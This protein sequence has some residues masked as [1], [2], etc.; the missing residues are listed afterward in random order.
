MLNRSYTSLLFLLTACLLLS[1]MFCPLYDIQIDDKDVYHY[2]GM[3]ILRGGVPYRDFFDHKPPLIF[4]LNAAGLLIGGWG[5]WVIDLAL[6]VL[7]T[8]VFF[9]TCERHKLPFPWLL[10]LLFNLMLR[11]FLISLGMGMT[12]GYTTMLQL[13]FFCVLIERRRYR[14]VIAGL[15]AGLIFFMQQDQV[16]F[17]APFLVASW[18]STGVQTVVKRLIWFAAG[19]GIILVP[20]LI[21]FVARG[22]L[23][24][25]WQDA[26]QF[27]FSWYTAQKG[28]LGYHFRIIKEALDAGNYEVPFLVSATLGFAALFL[29][30]RRKGWVIAGLAGLL[31]SMS[32]ELLGGRP[33]SPNF[34]YYFVPLSAGVVILLFIIFSFSEAAVI[35]DPKAQLIYGCLLCCSLSY[36]ALQHATHLIPANKHS[37]RQLAALHYLEEHPPGDF[38]LYTIGNASFIYAYND[39]HILAP[40]RWIYIHFW[41]WFDRWDADQSILKS[42]GDDLLRHHTR[43][44]WMD[45]ISM[46]EFRNP[47]NLAWW[48]DFLKTHYRPVPGLDQPHSTLWEWKGN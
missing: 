28:S 3:V 7:A 1:L 20:I 34:S 4:F 39:L 33:A 31:L 13:M 41:R 18:L 42:I 21:Y 9:R 17:V 22:S 32:S 14:D 47:T 26:F 23:G 43:Y 48:M 27:N 30:G 38:Q 11:D 10:P 46:A 35:R 36:T 2:G 40:S 25:F 16:M 6:A 5:L 15:L 37:T 19:F 24:F 45:P 8:V 12:R 29:P 44:I